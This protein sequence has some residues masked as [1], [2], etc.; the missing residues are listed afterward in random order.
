M[1]ET[2]RATPLDLDVQDMFSKKET[3]FVWDGRFLIKR[4]EESFKKNR[5]ENGKGFILK[6]LGGQGRAILKKQKVDCAPHPWEVLESLPSLWEGACLLSV[7]HLKWGMESWSS[8]GFEEELFF[9]PKV[10]LNP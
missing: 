1:P 3:S 4:S 8:A 5:Q 9:Y 7:P 6:S 10:S 2:K